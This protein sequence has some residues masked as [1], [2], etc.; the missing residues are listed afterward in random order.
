[1]VYSQSH[2]GLYSEFCMCALY[3]IGIGSMQ[4][5][6][7]VGVPLSHI[8]NQ[9]WVGITWVEAPVKASDVLVE[10]VELDLSLAHIST[11]SLGIRV[12]VILLTFFVLH[13]IYYIWHG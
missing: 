7:R 5:G 10:E 3:A 12:S 9:W 4:E 8:K 11:I 1:M 2:N 13:I 6:S